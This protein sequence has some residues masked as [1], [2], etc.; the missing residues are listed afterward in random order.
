MSARQKC[1]G[2]IVN[3]DNTSQL[4]DGRQVF[5]ATAVLTY[6]NSL[7]VP[8]TFLKV[9]VIGQPVTMSQYCARTIQPA[10]AY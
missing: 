2:E 5:F 7:L 9:T 6:N 10:F 3:I 4:I 8:G 1:T